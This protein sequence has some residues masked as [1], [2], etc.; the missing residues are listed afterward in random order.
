VED[1]EDNE[2]EAAELVAQEEEEAEQAG[3]EVR[4][5][6]VRVLEHGHLMHLVRQNILRPEALSQ[7]LLPILDSFMCGDLTYL[8]YQERVC[9]AVGLQWP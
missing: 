2:L 9:C 6:R 8:Q 3:E 4:E 5:I 1:D 7:S